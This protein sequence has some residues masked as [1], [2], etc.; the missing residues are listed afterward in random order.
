MPRKKEPKPELP[1]EQMVAECDYRTRDNALAEVKAGI[2][3][4]SHPR[5]TTAYG[6]AEHFLPVPAVPQTR[7]SRGGKPEPADEKALAAF[8]AA[9]AE[10]TTRERQLNDLAQKANGMVPTLYEWAVQLGKTEDRLLVSAPLTEADRPAVE[11]YV[12]EHQRLIRCC[13]TWADKL[14]Y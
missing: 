10:V 6:G 9:L 3:R 11:N 12:A 1:L 4:I 14:A 5:S 7:I 13:R 2:V 8:Q